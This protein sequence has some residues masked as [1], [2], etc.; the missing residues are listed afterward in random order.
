MA[1]EVCSLPGQQV[2]PVDRADADLEVGPGGES[3]RCRSRPRR[4]AR[5]PGRSRRPGRAPDRRG[6]SRCSGRSADPRRPAGPGPRGR[7]R[8]DSLLDDDPVGHRDL[9]G[10]VAARRAGGGDVDA[11]IGLPGARRLDHRS[12]AIGNTKPSPG[13]S[14]LSSCSMASSRLTSARDIGVSV[15]V[16][17]RVTGRLRGDRRPAARRPARSPAGGSAGRSRRGWPP[18]CEPGV[19]SAPADPQPASTTTAEASSHI[20]GRRMVIEGTQAAARNWAS[21]GRST[22]VSAGLPPARMPRPGPRAR[23]RRERRRGGRHAPGAWPP[24]RALRRPSARGRLS[25]WWSFWRTSRSTWARP[26][27]PTAACASSRSAMS[28]P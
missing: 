2:G 21:G 13:C 12:G 19:P 24:R 27:S 28:T 17:D 22:A 16:A 3:R 23:P 18:P 26:G 20:R 6:R 8:R 4:S 11:L 9:D 15:R 14:A 5:R 10:G 1:G 25:G 7:S